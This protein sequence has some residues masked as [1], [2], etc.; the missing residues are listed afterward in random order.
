LEGGGGGFLRCPLRHSDSGMIAAS[1]MIPS[2]SVSRASRMPG[3]GMGAMRIDSP[4]DMGLESNTETD[5]Q[6][7]SKIMRM[8]ARKVR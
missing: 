8:E 3:H 1:S 2:P 5:V 6:A 7:L 4:G